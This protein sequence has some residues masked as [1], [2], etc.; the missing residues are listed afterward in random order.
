MRKCMRRCFKYS[1]S[2]RESACNQ[3]IICA[4]ETRGRSFR[5]PLRAVHQHR[6]HF[7]V[8]SPVKML[9]QLK[10]YSY[11]TNCLHSPASCGKLSN[12]FRNAAKGGAPWRRAQQKNDDET[13]LRGSPCS[14]LRGSQ[15]GSTGQIRP[16]GRI[17]SVCRSSGMVYAALHMPIF[18]ACG[19]RKEKIWRVCT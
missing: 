7:A 18:Y 5:F 9:R 19:R 12:G 17:L 4:V 11:F 10:F 3:R 16:Q 6:P 1:Q 15:G 13:R 8:Y 2:I 14:G